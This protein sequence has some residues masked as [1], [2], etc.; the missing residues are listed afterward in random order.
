MEQF[1]F[2]ILK[3]YIEFILY[4]WDSMRTIYIILLIVFSSLSIYIY[5]KLDD[6]DKLNDSDGKF[7]LIILFIFIILLFLF[8]SP[9]T[10]Q[11]L[12]K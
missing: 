11:T 1:I 4:N 6:S 2:D 9:E 12:I 8:P 5:N 3:M 7:I 10:L